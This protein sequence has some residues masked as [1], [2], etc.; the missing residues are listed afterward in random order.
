MKPLVAVAAL[1]ALTLASPSPGFPQTSPA[2]ESPG[3]H[4]EERREDLQIHEALR[5]LVKELEAIKEGQQALHKDL[6]EMKT[7]L[8]TRPAAAPTAPQQAVLS[9]EGA[10][11]KGEQTA[12][13]T[14]IEFMDFQ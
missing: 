7:L 12:K 14:L 8:Q 11:F 6:Q 10:P 13:L 5:A 3:T 4:I 2:L 1:A 9:V